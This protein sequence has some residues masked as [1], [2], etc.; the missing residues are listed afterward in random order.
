[1]F[2]PNTLF[3]IGAG[4]GADIGMPTGADLASKIATTCNFRWEDGS[5]F[6]SGEIYI[7]NALKRH[8]APQ[9]PR[10]REFDPV[11]DHCVAGRQI[12]IGIESA[13]SIDNFIDRRS[14]SKEIK[15]LGKV[16]I[17][18]EILK[19]EWACCLFKLN[20]RRGETTMPSELRETWYDLF[21]KILFNGVSIGDVEDVFQNLT[22][23]CFNYDR[24]IEQYLTYALMPAYNLEF[25]QA[26]RLIKKLRINHPY[27]TVG[28]LPPQEN[29]DGMEFGGDE[30]GYKLFETAESIRT[31]SERNNDHQQLYEMKKRVQMA[32]RIIFLGFGFGQDNMTLL[33]PDC[34]NRELE[35]RMVWGTA[36][37]QS[38]TA[39]RALES[40][41][42]DYF[43]R[44]GTTLS[45]SLVKDGTCPA[46]LTEI[47]QVIQV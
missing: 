32:E 8:L 36:Y 20:A 42:G 39:I 28:Q 13:E 9:G 46:L 35:A 31:F 27:G 33:R 44:S 24:C 17:V 38:N 10:N 16:A 23:I 3:V 34:A 6:K 5:R 18:W 22:I 29:F 21:Q 4:A 26:E 37:S 1:M 12:H 19:A 2:P 30:E 11:R 14:D 25:E 47:R 7:L 41:I 40:Q 15:T 43:T 45:G